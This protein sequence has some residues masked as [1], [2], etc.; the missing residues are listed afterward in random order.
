VSPTCLLSVSIFGTSIDY[1]T[2]LHYCWCWDFCSGNVS[3][4]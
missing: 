1:C 2:L 4:K 3:H